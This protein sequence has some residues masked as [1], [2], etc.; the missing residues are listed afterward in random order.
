MNNT[1]CKEDNSKVIHSKIP[2]VN[3]DLK[4]RALS[5]IRRSRIDKAKLT[6]MNGKSSS[7]VFAPRKERLE[8]PQ[9][10]Q[11]CKSAK[12][13]NRCYVKNVVYEITC[14][15][16][17]AVYVGETRRT[18]GSRVSKLSTN[19]FFLTRTELLLC[20]KSAGRFYMQIYHN[21]PS[22]NTLKHLKFKIVVTR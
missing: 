8:C 2:F 9:S 10:C 1:A 21:I 15:H 17:S 7:R 11:S 22:A 20:L 4:R 13:S 3:E 19:I 6:F 14:Q 18:V 5:V 12:K 16:S